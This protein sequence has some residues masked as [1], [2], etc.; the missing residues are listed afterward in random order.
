MPTP[1]RTQSYLLSLTQRQRRL[2]AASRWLSSPWCCRFL[3]IADFGR[4][5]QASIVMEAAARNGAEAAAQEYLQLKRGLGVLTST[6][7]ARIHAVALE[8]VCGE[9]E[10]LPNR[11]QSGSTCTMPAVAVCIYDDDAELPGYEAGG[12]CGTERSTAPPECD[13]LQGWS[14]VWPPVGPTDGLPYVEVRVC[15]RFTTLFNLQDIQLPLANGLSLG[16][17]WLQKDRAFTVADY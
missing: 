16:D 7:Y 12:W 5:F 13:A 8:A 17:I 9:A 10:R 14:H 3:G 15:Y 11:V 6:E 2:G 1:C 4:V